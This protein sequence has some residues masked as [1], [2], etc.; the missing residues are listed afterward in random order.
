MVSHP[1]S[2][3]FMIAIFCI[4][5]LLPPLQSIWRKVSI[6]KESMTSCLKV[7]WCLNFYIYMPAYLY[8]S[9]G[10]RLWMIVRRNIFFPI[11]HTFRYTRFLLFSVFSFCLIEHAFIQWH[12]LDPLIA[13]K[14]TC[15]CIKTHNCKTYLLLYRFFVLYISVMPK[16]SQTPSLLQSHPAGFP[17]RD[18]IS[19]NKT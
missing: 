9:C 17:T 3:C 8:V 12:T 18:R 11:R 4:C 2:H 6:I 15:F 19:P 5:F 14:Y 10:F 16:V 13:A 7:V 1:H